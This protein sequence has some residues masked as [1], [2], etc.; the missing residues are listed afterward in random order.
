MCRDAE[1]AIYLYFPPIIMK[2]WES[3]SGT[4]WRMKNE[5]EALGNGEVEC[6]I[7]DAGPFTVALRAGWTGWNWSGIGTEMQL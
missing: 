5:I 2:T 6:I 3:G 4:V 7:N 1:I